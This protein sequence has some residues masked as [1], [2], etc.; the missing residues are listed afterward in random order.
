MG[1]GAP[2]TLGPGQ[3]QFHSILTTA[4]S[5]DSLWGR[6]VCCLLYPYLLN[7]PSCPTHTCFDLLRLGVH[8]GGIPHSF[9]GPCCQPQP[10]LQAK[11]FLG[12][13]C[14]WQQKVKS[15][16][17]RFAPSWACSS[18]GSQQT[19]LRPWP[20]LSSLF[21]PTLQTLERRL[22]SPGLGGADST[23]LLPRA[24]RGAPTS[25]SG[26]QTHP[27]SLAS[28]IHSS[29]LGSAPFIIVIKYPPYPLMLQPSSP[30]MGETVTLRFPELKPQCVQMRA[31]CLKHLM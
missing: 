12:W 22:A 4:C 3:P 20:T 26:T 29:C 1:P 23:L 13:C 25:L 8:G 10:V 27:V 30:A 15:N 6:G 9:S 24:H 21:L 19:G 28:P 11:T 7:L 17:L 2:S 18:L 14:L 5:P 16:L 31:G